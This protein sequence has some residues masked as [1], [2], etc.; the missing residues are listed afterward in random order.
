MPDKN[1]TD[2]KRIVS[3]VFTRRDEIEGVE[4]ALCEIDAQLTERDEQA[5]VPDVLDL[6]AISSWDG[7]RAAR[8]AVSAQ[9]KRWHEREAVR[10]RTEAYELVE[11]V[12]VGSV[13]YV[14]R[15]TIRMRRDSWGYGDELEIVEHDRGA[16]VVTVRVARRDGKKSRA[17]ALWELD[18][19]DILHFGLSP[20]APP[21]FSDFELKL[22]QHLK[23]TRG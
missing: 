1:T 14:H 17:R 23:R 16:E 6:D 11:R 19:G 13:L 15:K 8:Q 9:A 2:P 10:K 7:L 21:P 22:A 12:P 4:Q 20:E 3:L 18:A 5:A